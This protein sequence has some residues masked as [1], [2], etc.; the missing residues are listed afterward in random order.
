M[1]SQDLI[2]ILK[3]IAVGVIIFLIPFLIFFIGLWI[4]RHAL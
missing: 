2:L 4:V 3:K 1:I